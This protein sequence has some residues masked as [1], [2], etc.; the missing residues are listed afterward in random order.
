MTSEGERQP[1]ISRQPLSRPNG[2]ST[3]STMSGP[4]SSGAW[5]S[6]MMGSALTSGPDSIFAGGSIGG[7]S[8]SLPAAASGAVSMVWDGGP[9]AISIGVA[10]GGSGSI[11]GA[12]SMPE[13]GTRHSKASSRPVTGE[14]GSQRSET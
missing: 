13:S 3:S 12:P 11:T 8:D 2:T 7:N 4:G 9:D 1:K 5:T 6:G 10:T 14:A